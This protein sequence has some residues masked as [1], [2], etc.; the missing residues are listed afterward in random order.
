MKRLFYLLVCVLVIGF[1]VKTVLAPGNT[2]KEPVQ[3]TEA[4]GRVVEMEPVEQAEPEKKFD[5]PLQAAHAVLMELDSGKILYAK[6]EMG[7][8]FPASTTK[9]LTALV[10]LENGETKRRV[11]VGEEANFP[12]PGSSLAGIRYGETLTLNQLLY[13]LLL[14]SGNDAAYA[15]AVDT[16]RRVSGDRKMDSHKAVEYFCDLMNQRAEKAGARGSHFV[17]PDGYHDA[18]HYTT[19]L[20]MAYIARDAMKLKAFREVVQK[21]EYRLPNVKGK[22]KDGKSLMLK[23]VVQNTNRLINKEDPVYFQ[24]AT[25]IKTG[26]TTPAGYCLVSSAAKDGRQVLAVV[27]NSSEQGVWEDTRSLLEWGLDM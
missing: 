22:G 5:Q 9:I 19:A 3:Q 10:A 16:A 27:M 21:P 8:C 1:G 23:R 12:S 4:T 13:A 24:Y 6:S 26:H 20:D 25:G 11:K 7:T 14:P 17:S 15:L 18:E 2:P